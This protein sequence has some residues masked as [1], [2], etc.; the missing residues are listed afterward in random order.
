L[1]VRAPELDTGEITGDGIIVATP[2]GSTGY[3]RSVTRS[4]VSEGIGVAFN[5]CTEPFAPLCLASDVA[6]EV[7]VLRGPAVLA[8]D[9]DPRL[10]P[11][12]DGHVFEVGRAPESAVVLGLDALRCQRCRKTDGSAFNPH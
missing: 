1:R 5:N 2:F 10:L 7:E 11:M 4:T 3:Y 8:R 6:I 9:N 12:R